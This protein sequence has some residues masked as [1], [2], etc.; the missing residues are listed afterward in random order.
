MATGERDGH[1]RTV[2]SGDSASGRDSQGSSLLPMLVAGLVL[3]LVGAI[4]VMTFV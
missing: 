1:E 4:V 3:I 2:L